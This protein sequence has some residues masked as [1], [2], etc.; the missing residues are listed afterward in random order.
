MDK[1]PELISQIRPPEGPKWCIGGTSLLLLKHSCLQM[2]DQGIS[3]RKKQASGDGLVE[4]A[5]WERPG[6]FGGAFRDSVTVTTIV[7]ALVHVTR[8]QQPNRTA[9]QS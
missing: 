1:I 4:S 2:L 3:I 7:L 9:E 5:G 8:W 6:G